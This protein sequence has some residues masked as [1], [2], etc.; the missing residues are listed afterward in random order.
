MKR[1]KQLLAILMTVLL[2]FSSIVPGDMTLLTAYA[3]DMPA[4]TEQPSSEEE[5]L[6]PEENS[7]E[8]SEVSE[9]TSEETDTVINDAAT[10]NSLEESNE[11]QGE[12]SSEQSE[13]QENS[14]PVEESSEISE[15]S[16]NTYVEETNEPKEESSDPKAENSEPVEESSLPVEESSE[17]NEESSVPVEE[18]SVIVEE[19]SSTVV[20]ESSDLQTSAEESSNVPTEESSVVTEESSTI[21]ETEKQEEPWSKTLTSTDNRTYL[22]TV[23][24]DHTSGVPADAQL[25]V[26]EIVPGMQDYDEYMSK[27]AE[28]TGVEEENIS[29]ARAFDIYLLDPATGAHIS[30]SQSVAVSIELLSE[31]INKS[32]EEISVVHFEDETNQT[33]IME[34][35]LNG[36]AIEFETDGFSV[37]VVTGFTIEKF[38]EAS[39][40]KTY[41]ITV[42]FKEDALL[43]DGVG[44]SVRELTGNEYAEYVGSASVAMKAAGFEYARVF[45]ISL[46]DAQGMEVQPGAKVDVTVELM[47]RIA[48]GANYSVIHFAEKIEAEE[49]LVSEQPEIVLSET[50]GN[51]VTF[52]ASGFSAYAIVQGPGEVPI[53]W[54]KLTTLDELKTDEAIYMGHASGYYFTSGI[55][56]I[57]DD[58]TGITK[59]TPAQT[60]PAS[61]A[62]PYYFEL[63]DG[64][65]N[66]FK[67]YCMDGT[68][69]KYILQSGNSLNFTTENLATAFTISVVNHNQYGTCFRALGNDGYYWNMQAG[70]S[71][72]SFAA[73][74]GATDVNA[75]FYFWR[76]HEPDYDPYKLDGKSYGLMSWD[77]ATTG[78]AM[79]G[80]VSQTGRLD[81]MNLTVLFKRE[82]NA[83]KLFTPNDS[84]ITKWTFHYERADLYSIS[85]Q[86]D[87]GLRYLQITSEGISLV[88]EKNENCNIKIVPGTG[89]HS[90]QICLQSQDGSNTISYS[91]VLAD[92]F[93]VGGSAGSEWLFLVGDS[94]LTNEYIMTYSASKVSISDPSVTTGSRVIIYTRVWNENTLKYE[95]YAVD[96]DGSLVRCYESG[97][98]I[99]WLAGRI[100]TVLWNFTEY[101]EED[102]TAN[103]YYELFNQYSEKFIA[104]QVTGGQILQDDVIGIN[105]NGRKEKYY[106]STILAWD[107]GNYAFV[108]LKADSTTGKIVSCPISEAEDFYFAIMYDIP[109]DD[110]L[111]EVPTIDHEQYGITMK[112]VDL[113]NVNHNNMTGWMNSYLGTADSSVASNGHPAHPISGIL[114]NYIDEETHYP[115]VMING[116]SL[117]GMFSEY[118]QVNHLFIASTY[119]GS[120]YYEFDSSQNFAHLNLDT[121][122]FTV[123]KGIA[124]HDAS[125]KDSLKHGQFFPFNDIEPG[126]FASVNRKNLFSAT[127]QPLSDSD[128]RKNEV[129]YL[130]KQPDYYFAVDIEAS[131]TQT[132]GGVDNWGHD[133]I[134]EFTGDDDFWLYVDGELIID[135]G[136]IHSAIGGSVN[137][138]TG[139]V[140]VNGV[141]Y[142]LRELFEKNYRERNEYPAR[143]QATSDENAAVDAF[144]AKYFDEGK[145]IFKDYTTH[146]MRIF[147]ME[148]GASASNL[149]MRFNLASVKPGTVELTKELDGIDESVSVLAEYPY[150]IWYTLPGAEEGDEPVEELLV[151]NAEAGVTVRHKDTVNDVTFFES[152]TIPD[153]GITY[154]DVFMVRPGE[155]I[156]I[157]FPEDTISYKVIECGVNTDVYES[158]SVNKIQLEGTAVEGST[159]RKDFALDYISIADRPKV[160]YVNKVRESAIRT[161]RITKELFKEDGTT[162]LT[163]DNSVF[164]F[165]LYLGTEFDKKLSSA[166][167]YTYHVKDENGNYCKWNGSGF[168]SIGETN[169]ENL[170]TEQKRSVTFNTSIF[171]SISKIPAFYTVEVPNILAGTTFRVQERPW[172]IPDGYSFQKYLYNGRQY[173]DAATGVTDTAVAN[174]DPEVTV[175]NIRG[176]GLRVNK[177]W[178]DTDYMEFR[179]ATY[180]GVFVK[181]EDG[182]LS[183]IPSNLEIRDE[184]GDQV[185]PIRRMDFKDSNNKVLPQTLY[186]Y[187]PLLISDTDLDDYVIR[188]V[189]LTNPGLDENGRVTYDDYQV[190]DPGKNITLS[191]VQRGESAAGEFSYTVV[192][193]TGTVAEGS[194]V[195]VDTAGNNRQGIQLKKTD[196][197]GIG[198][199]G[200]VFELKDSEERLIGTF[201]SDEN[202]LITTAFLSNDAT[203]TLTEISAPQGYQGLPQVMTL[204]QSA[205][206]TLTVGGVD[207][208]YYLLDQRPG[209]ETSLTIKNRPYEL[210]VVKVDA[211]DDTI[212]LSGVHFALH[213]QVTVDGV[214]TI[215]FKPMEGY[216]DLVTNKNGVIVEINQTLPAGTYELREKEPAEGY[217]ILSGNI[218]FTISPT[219]FITLG[220]HP[221]G[222]T[223]VETEEDGLV[224]YTLKIGNWIN[225][226]VLTLTK[227]VTGDLGEK[228]KE[229]SFTLTSVTGQESDKTYSWT[230]TAADGTEISGSISVNESF[231]LKHG[232]SIAITLP[233]DET[234]VITENDT[235]SYI[236]T[237]SSADE[238]VRITN[239]DTPAASLVLRGD[240]SVTVTNHLPA[241]APT[242]YESNRKPYA[243]LLIGGA[244]LGAGM[245]LVRR[246]RRDEE[247]LEETEKEGQEK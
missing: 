153:T 120:G 115:K 158:V 31:N 167:M 213:R 43:P 204:S 34:T 182:I 1:S 119:N 62:V 233:L 123:Y 238:T 207:E 124:T 217:K 196:W 106:Q 244:V 8:D 51:I 65:E 76:Y 49:G 11:S 134:Y 15:E 66:Q 72:K 187:F 237:W 58:R 45:D 189:K 146:T 7:Q 20:E 230:K 104:P 150:Q 117:A 40:G 78:K 227:Q 86:T 116:N 107:D 26:T 239:E 203:Y 176:Y 144:L 192:Y 28:K 95:F 47:D 175:C 186:W 21:V 36:E 243:L 171:G 179:E 190:I 92:G 224:S 197:T 108:G 57:K 152:F 210:T 178:S 245:L 44:L 222:V 111:M 223:L 219:G 132:E 122:W 14:Q 97:D 10:E 151:P 70:A 80:T 18:S 133:I 96:H 142:T 56:K 229:F 138:R 110:T 129:L 9:E 91:G 162:Q 185:T 125:S 38:V 112:I 25:V 154:Q 101:F 202:G 148:R 71:G 135:L 128:P 180:F 89:A 33:E 220:T 88:S 218:R 79:M 168:V 195:R 24:F 42:T 29:F 61:A 37:Y 16:S 87:E 39:D 98:H 177:V 226:G 166:Y 209:V 130:I 160:E 181:N 232:E 75:Q 194:H 205:D 85:A 211:T 137:Y 136:G 46:V 90:N 155:T 201:T 64:T 60:Y 131:F 228:N 114:S 143:N 165:R 241:P 235:G 3:Q 41:K 139:D 73:Y 246:R 32:D 225:E 157:D 55:T 13:E 127:V 208:S 99:Q 247:D 198:L 94:E 145:T 191:G 67:V 100:N 149:H 77:E 206:G 242:N 81:A 102:G 199:A 147:Y 69:R 109:V 22:I 4:E 231:K 159:N 174:Q 234:V 105:L 156:V 17:A 215:D 188:E 59:T 214:T 121:N 5:N 6:L 27:S 212:L 240:A 183:L 48:A 221:D 19:E 53:G 83:D 12:E 236:V 140:Y 93:K 169:Y 173:D 200:A 161:L 84:E 170:S 103:G 54:E 118:R 35:E 2:V 74:T 50:T 216:E 63:V 23:K 82:N 68:N 52:A 163:N 193:Q 30:P 172:E 141:H 113:D 184:N 126:V 164:T